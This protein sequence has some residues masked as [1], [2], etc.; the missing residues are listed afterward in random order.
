MADTEILDSILLSVKKNIGIHKTATEFD[1]DLIMAINSAIAVLR[2]LGVGSEDFSI[3]DETATWTDFIGSAKN[4][5]MIKTYVS[6]KVGII[7]D[8]PQNSSLLEAKKE[9]LAEME[10]R[11]NVTVDP[12]DKEEEQNGR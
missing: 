10:W 3:K 4:L 1:E 6:A 7:F 9:L 5:E 12:G 8:P 11:I 2:Q